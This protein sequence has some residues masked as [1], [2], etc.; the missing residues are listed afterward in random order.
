M[1]MKRKKHQQRNDMKSENGSKR[2]EEEDGKNIN[3][4][5]NLIDVGK[6]SAKKTVILLYYLFGKT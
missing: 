6:H 3:C 1:E 4:A 2:R 5:N